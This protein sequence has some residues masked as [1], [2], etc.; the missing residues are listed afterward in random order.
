MYLVGEIHLIT[1]RKTASRERD[2]VIYRN[3]GFFTWL[4]NRTMRNFPV[5]LNAS[6]RYYATGELHIS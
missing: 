6:V 2:W 5:A 4:G 3:F 1:T